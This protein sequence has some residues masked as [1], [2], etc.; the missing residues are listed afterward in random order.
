MNRVDRL[1][2]SIKFCGSAMDCILNVV[3]VRMDKIKR[4]LLVLKGMEE[5]YFGLIERYWGGCIF[6]SYVCVE[7]YVFSKLLL[8]YKKDTKGPFMY[9]D[10]NRLIITY[11]MLY[12]YCVIHGYNYV[13]YVK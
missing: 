10:E 9:D 8:S 6:A 1:P 3:P 2:L 5:I 12:N 4:P 13:D 11:E 7:G